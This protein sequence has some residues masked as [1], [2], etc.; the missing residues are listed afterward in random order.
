MSEMLEAVV[1]V[2]NSKGQHENL[3]LPKLCHLNKL[4]FTVAKN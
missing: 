4:M 2:L 3:R 1:I